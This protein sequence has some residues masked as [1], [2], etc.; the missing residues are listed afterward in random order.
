M[1]LLVRA[2][3]QFDQVVKENVAVSVAKAVHLIFDLAGVM[4]DREAGFPRFKVLMAA[5]SGTQFLPEIQNR[6]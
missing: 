4:M 2:L 1:F 6:I 3:H 5:N